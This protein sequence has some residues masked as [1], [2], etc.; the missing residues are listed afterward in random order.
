MHRRGVGQFGDALGD[1][2]GALAGE[3]RGLR[4]S[5]GRG[6]GGD[7]LAPGPVKAQGDAA[8]P[9]VYPQGHVRAGHFQPVA[10]CEGSGEETHLREASPIL[11]PREAERER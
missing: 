11:T 4:Q 3:G 6:G 1:P 8:G 10:I 5:A 9:A 2:G 7:D